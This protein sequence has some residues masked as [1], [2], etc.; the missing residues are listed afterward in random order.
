MASVTVRVDDETKAKWLAAAKADRRDL[1]DF[2]RLTIDDA[3]ENAGPPDRASRGSR[4][5]PQDSPTAQEPTPLEQ[6]EMRSETAEQG[7]G[8]PQDFDENSGRQIWRENAVDFTQ[9]ATVPEDDWPDG[10]EGEKEDK[11]QRFELPAVE[12][13]RDDDVQVERALAM[14]AKADAADRV[15]GR[16]GSEATLDAPEPPERADLAP[17]DPTCPVATSH[18]RLGF[19]ER[20]HQ[21]GGHAT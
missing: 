17:L 2:V 9:G 3:L 18:W 11:R 10:D 1:S 15:A 21:C 13:Y 12:P 4:G 5:Q 8:D 14:R 6:A 20:C 19:R 7:L 16:R